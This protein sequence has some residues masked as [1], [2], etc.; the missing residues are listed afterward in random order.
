MG[1]DHRSCLL[2]WLLILQRGFP[3]RWASLTRLIPVWRSA[4]LK[5]DS[6]A[7]RLSPA[8]L[9]LIARLPE[10]TQ[11]T[12]AEDDF[13]AVFGQGFPTVNEL[14][15]IIDQDLQTLRSMPWKLEDETLVPKAGACL[16]CP[17]RSG[18]QPML[19]AAEDAPQNGKIS[20]TD[21]CLD[22][23]C[24][25]RK[26][27]AH[28]QR[29]EVE[30]RREKPNLVLIRTGYGPLSQ[31]AEKVWGDKVRHV[32]SPV[33]VKASDPTAVPVMQ[34]EGP[35][36]GQVAYIADNG[37]RNGGAKPGHRGNK[38]KSGP[39]SPAERRARHQRRRDA[40]VVKRV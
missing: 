19:F 15:R 3:R 2:C 8:H 20:K 28:V 11:A 22:L 32:Y 26:L 1:R 7:S 30:A 31:T 39:L 13:R 29:C 24:F 9:E 27:L 36:A 38:E 10:T 37:V 4:I 16:N 34:I 6:E 12:L 5:S 33:F 40:F 25:D 14:R 18:Q 23:A 21:R 35:K 17:K